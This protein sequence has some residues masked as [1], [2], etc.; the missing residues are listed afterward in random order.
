MRAFT[1]ALAVTIAAACAAAS[2]H[3]SS[4]HI[5]HGAVG[6]VVVIAAITRSPRAW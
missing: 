3:G 6:E 1:F 4:P 2:V 5:P